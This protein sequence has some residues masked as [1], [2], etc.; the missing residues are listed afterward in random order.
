MELIRTSVFAPTTETLQNYETNINFDI[1]FLF[2]EIDAGFIQ[3]FGCT[4]PVS[5]RRINESCNLGEFNS[6][7]KNQFS[8]LLTNL[9]VSSWS[10]CRTPCITMGITLGYPI[11]AKNDVPSESYLKFYFK[12]RVNVRKSVVAYSGTSLMAEV[13]G[14]IG[15]LLG[16]SLLDLTKLV[17]NVFNL[18]KVTFKTNPTKESQPT[19]VNTEE[20]SETISRCK[21]SELTDIQE[22]N[23]KPVYIVDDL[24]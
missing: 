6:V 12:S 19:M 1:A 23:K 18:G 17:K 20:N 14:Y 7:Q 13:G 3:V 21:S 8:Y 22:I 15:L 24:M 4:P 2:Q 11:Y 9:T 5:T 10:S 16:F